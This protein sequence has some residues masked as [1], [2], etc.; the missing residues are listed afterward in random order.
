MRRSRLYLF[1]CLALLLVALCVAMLIREQAQAPPH[2]QSTTGE[3][4][5]ANPNPQQSAATQFNKSKHSTTDPA[6][7]WVIVN[8][9]HPMQPMSYGPSDLVTVGNG[10]SLRSEAATAFNQMVTGAKTAG[11]TIYA[12]SAYRSYGTQVIV[13]NREVATYGQATADSQSAR[14]GYS[15][16]QTGWAID[17]GGGGCNITDCFADTAQGKWSAENA[18]T[19]G[20]ILRYT[21][22]DITTTGYRAESW[23]FRY[24]GVELAQELHKQN[25][26][27]LEQF[28]GVTGGSTYAN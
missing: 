15:E 21:P 12:A 18:H 8:K 10:Q 6:S 3:E 13:Y 7:P 11:L 2:S 4:A 25:I 22:S 20:F 23:H 5:K 16:H 24:V 26:A 28:F 9:Q 14:P 27:T 1:I 17:I 19:Y